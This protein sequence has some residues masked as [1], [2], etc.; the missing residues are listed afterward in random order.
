M[1]RT[2][3]PRTR[4]LHNLSILLGTLAWAGCASEPDEG[5]GGSFSTTQG[6]ARARPSD[7]AIEEQVATI[8]CDGDYAR[9]VHGFRLGQNCAAEVESLPGICLVTASTVTGSGEHLCF[10][11]SEGAF[12]LAFVRYGESIAGESLRHGMGTQWPDQLGVEEA[13]TCGHLMGLLE[14]RSDEPE[15]AASGERLYVPCE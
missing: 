7:R 4:A 15:G 8:H 12:F 3:L 2:L 13:E 10:L 14:R 5:G 6:A 1:D 9:P 11:S